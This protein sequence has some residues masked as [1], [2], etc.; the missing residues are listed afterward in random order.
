MSA[1]KTDLQ[2]KLLGG[3]TLGLGT[4][5]L[6]LIH[7]WNSNDKSPF[8]GWLWG[9]AFWLSVAI[10]MLMLIM[11]FRVFNSEWTP[12]VRRQLEHGL[13]AFPWLALCF[14]PLVA[15]AL[16]GG[17]N[18][19]I[20]WSWVNPATS[21]IEV[22][23]EIT[24]GEDVLHQKKASYL[25]LYFFVFR[26]ILYFAIFCG[27]GYWMRKVSFSQDLDGDPKWTHLGMKLSAVGIPAAAL[28]L[29]FGAFDMFMSLEYQ[30]FSTMYGV[31]FFAGSIR[32]A[33][34]VTIITCLYLS[35]K[36]SLQGIYK[37]AH[38]YD[39]AC[40]SLAFTVFWA[41]IS[42][43]QY[44]LIYSANIPEETF[45]YTIREINPNTGERSG[46]FWVS[47][48]LI[49]GHFFFPFLYLLFYRNKIVAPRIVFIVCWILLFHLL[50]LYWNIIPGRE[51]APGS[52]VGMEAR[53]F[54]GSYLLWG[55]ASLFGVG[56]ICAWAVCRS[57]KSSEA[58]SI[59][60]RD[61]RILESLNYHE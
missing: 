4:G 41:Y 34:A 55:L 20:L 26:M 15:F 17:D 10:G 24:V 49:F 19:G 51:I 30:W 29:T 31:W 6:G 56:C 28:A 43:S 44:F 7:G 21:T 39:L 25:N 36:G 11:I 12:I 27:L 37:Q 59:P 57:Y 3:A 14:A 5:L 8:L 13:A 22:T 61:P 33:L 60:V 42:F 32:A 48:G 54:F 50:D 16:F 9:S 45:W 52:A 18:S 35:T 53:P 1:E 47:M 46:W 23:S 2:I 38:Q 58:E 40:L